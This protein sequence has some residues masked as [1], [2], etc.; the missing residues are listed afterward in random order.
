MT[1][2]PICY[3]CDRPYSTHLPIGERPHVICDHDMPHRGTMRF[4]RKDRIPKRPEEEVREL[5]QLLRERDTLITTLRERL[6]NSERDAYEF[7]RIVDDVRR[8]VAV[9]FNLRSGWSA[10]PCGSAAETYGLNG[11]PFAV[12]RWRADQKFMVYEGDDPRTPEGANGMYLDDAMDLAETLAAQ[13]KAKR[14]E[15][16]LDSV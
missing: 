2:D 13:A 6:A 8:A 3:N 10:L 7:Q 15:E 5:R 1:E 11:T 14:R 16:L 9:K 12:I 4:V